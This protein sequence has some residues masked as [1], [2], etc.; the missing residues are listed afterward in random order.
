M[1]WPGS[2]PPVPAFTFIF[3]PPSGRVRIAEGLK[4]AFDK[5]KVG[6]PMR[7]KWDG[8]RGRGSDPGTALRPD[9]ILGSRL[10]HLLDDIPGYRT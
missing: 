3:L 10:P 5:A 4:Q 2:E 7:Y 1:S 6:Q 9:R 8:T